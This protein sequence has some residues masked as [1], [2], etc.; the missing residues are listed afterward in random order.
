MNTEGNKKAALDFLE[1]VIAGK[2]D[3]AYEKYVDMNGKHH[4]VAT[5]AGM[6]ELNKGMKGAEEQFPNK[7]F[8]VQHVVGDGDFVAVHSHL[9]L[10]VGAVDFAAVHLFRFANGKI[11]E[12][13]DVAQ[14]ITKSINADGAF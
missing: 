9:A 1:L 10:K 2:I 12:L 13:W 7:Q 4:N 14:D 3:E 11:V 8:E 6:T 5:L